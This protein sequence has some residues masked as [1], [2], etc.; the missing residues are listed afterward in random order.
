MPNNTTNILTEIEDAVDAY[1]QAVDRR[2]RAEI[3]ACNHQTTSDW[4][5]FYKCQDEEVEARENVLKVVDGV[6]KQASQEK[7]T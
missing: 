3:D 6:L 2:V 4:D 7:V 5:R 1:G